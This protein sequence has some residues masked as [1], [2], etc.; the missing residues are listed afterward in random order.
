MIPA[1]TGIVITASILPVR[2]CSP[3]GQGL[4]LF[5]AVSPAPT[6]KSFINSSFSV[7]IDI[8]KSNQGD[9]TALSIVRK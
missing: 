7:L 9:Q 8:F 6:S 1:I 4:R 2:L 5:R 3:G